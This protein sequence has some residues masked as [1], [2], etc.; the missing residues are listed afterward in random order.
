[1]LPLTLKVVPGVVVPN[2]MRLFAVS[3]VRNGMAVVDVAMEKALTLS[4]RMVV[5]ATVLKTRSPPPSVM[6]CVER[7]VRAV[8][9]S[10]EILPDVIVRLPEVMSMFPDA[11]VM[12]F[13][14]VMLLRL[15]MSWETV[16]IWIEEAADW[17][18]EDAVLE[19]PDISFLTY[20]RIW[21]LMVS[22]Y[23]R[24]SFL[25]GVRSAVTISVRR[26]VI[27]R[28]LLVSEITGEIGG[29]FSVSAG[30]ADTELSTM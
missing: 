16:T 7:M 10:A 17:E 11:T 18:A 12:P 6:S 1:M 21:A 2:P 14:T 24:S 28:I 26:S 29:A 3:K 25:T 15:S 20:S 30:V 22:R 5:V 4:E 13:L 19:M 9:I 23:A 8:R 27:S